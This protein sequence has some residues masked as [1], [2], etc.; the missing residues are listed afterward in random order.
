MPKPKDDYDVADKDKRILIW[1]IER[2]KKGN[3]DEHNDDTRRSKNWY[4][5]RNKR[6][7]EKNNEL[8]CLHETNVIKCEIHLMCWER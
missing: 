3:K 6:M 2:G 5:N 7:V 4:I 1:R 8:N